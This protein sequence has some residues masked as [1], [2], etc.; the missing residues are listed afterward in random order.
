MIKTLEMKKNKIQCE[1]DSTEYDTIKG[2][3]SKHTIAELDKFVINNQSKLSLKDFVAMQ[4]T[5]NKEE[6]S[7]SASN[8]GYSG[9][10]SNSGDSGISVSN[11]FFGTVSNKAGCFSFIVENEHKGKYTN[12]LII[13]KQNA[14]TVKFTKEMDGKFYTLFKNK[15]YEVIEADDIKTLVL[16]RKKQGDIDIV[17][18]IEFGNDI[19]IYK[20]GM[21]VDKCKNQYVVIIPDGVNSHGDTVEQAIADLRY[22]IGNRDTTAYEYLRTEKGKVK[23]DDLIK[24]Y[25]VITGACMYGTKS[26]V[27]GLG[28]LV[29][30][31]YTMIEA[32]SLLQTK[33][34]YAL[35]K[36]ID[37]L[38]GGK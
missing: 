33:N 7:G 35:D 2:L 36:F 12:G 22:K 31:E 20:A 26:F 21:T 1:G 3:L 5:E 17:K 37:F 6:A 18:G 11:S 14:K 24:A 13:T 34:A 8:S 16:E 28:D 25:R 29:K 19:D 10:A 9:S 38:G 4:E 30:D 27:E 32:I 15:I 23:T